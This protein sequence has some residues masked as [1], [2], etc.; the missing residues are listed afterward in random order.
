MESASRLTFIIPHSSFLL[1]RFFRS[2]DELLR[3]AQVVGCGAGRPVSVEADAAERAGRGGGTSVAD[4]RA[5]G[6]RF[7]LTVQPVA[8]GAA[9]GSG[10]MG[11][12]AAGER[13]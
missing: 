1:H 6:E 12:S 2:S 3:A 13:G 7:G 11:D 9:R 10:Q 5:R 4:E 8:E